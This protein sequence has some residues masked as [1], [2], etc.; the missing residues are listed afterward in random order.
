MRPT[1]RNLFKVKDLIQNNFKCLQNFKK[2][3]KWCFLV[4]F[5]SI[6]FWFGSFP[7]HFIFFLNNLIYLYSSLNWK[8]NSWNTDFSVI[9]LQSPSLSKMEAYGFFSLFHWKIWESAQ[10]KLSPTGFKKTNKNFWLLFAALPAR[11]G[12]R[13]LISN[14][15]QSTSIENHSLHVKNLIKKQSTGK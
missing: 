5:R 6:S 12:I 1:S 7:H 15:N 4:S 14:K 9:N 8:S 3:K 13:S 11:F 10:R 2:F